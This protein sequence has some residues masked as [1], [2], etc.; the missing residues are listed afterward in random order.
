M[1]Y[2]LLNLK[3]LYSPPDMME[4]HGTQENSVCLFNKTRLYYEKVKI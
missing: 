4:V 1:T 2:R 3:L